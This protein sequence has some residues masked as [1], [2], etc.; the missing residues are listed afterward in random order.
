MTP[1]EPGASEQDRPVLMEHCSFEFT[2]LYLPMLLQ[3]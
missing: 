1:G 3:I 2:A